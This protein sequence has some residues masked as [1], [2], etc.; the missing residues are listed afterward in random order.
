MIL[1]QTAPI[2]N[3]YRVPSST[4]AY[5]LRVGGIIAMAAELTQQ[6]LTSQHVGTA[7]CKIC[8]GVL[9]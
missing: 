8:T 9:Q 1:V 7:A 5:V 4:C 3:S 6:S 2:C